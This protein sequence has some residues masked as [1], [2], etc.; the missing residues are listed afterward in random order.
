MG[1][2]TSAQSNIGGG[3][4]EATQ[5]FISTLKQLKNIILHGPVPP[6][7][8]AKAINNMDA[9]LICYDVQKDQSKGTNYH[10]I[11][12]YLSTGKV[13]ISNNVTTYQQYPG[14]IEMIPERDNNQTLPG[15]FKQVIERLQQYNS[16][17]KQAQRVS[18][19]R[20][21]TYKRQIERIE[22]ILNAK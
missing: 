12:E 7:F 20:D 13:I 18:F 15:L 6:A 16:S 10:K 17:T 14:L 8:L 22:T 21:N 19:A 2:Y 3:E 4:N 1:S 5:I 11:I 9:F